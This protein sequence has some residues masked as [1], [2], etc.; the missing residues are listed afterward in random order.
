MSCAPSG[1]RRLIDSLSRRGARSSSPCGLSGSLGGLH[2]SRGAPARAS[3]RP[4][5]R[6]SRTTRV[7]LRSRLVV[8]L[9]SLATVLAIAACGS[10]SPPKTAESSGTQTPLAYV[11]C[12]RSHGVP[13]MPDPGAAGGIQLPA[14]VNPASPA[15]ES[16]LASCAR[17]M[18]A[19]A[20]EARSAPSQ[21]A[22]EQLL[23]LSR[24]MRSHGVAEFPDPTLGGPPSNPQDYSIAFGR[25]G[26]SMLVPSTV[27]VSSP[28]FKQAAVAC[29]FGALLPRGQRTPVPGS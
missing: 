6:W 23:A 26:V 10:S 29:H 19:G 3:L 4:C 13:Q 16:A 12:M 22:I 18:P 17:L 7:M 8:L 9:G 2:H 24:C 11:H 20:S 5:Y 25:G 27:D 28:A 14:D 21:Q 1:S 15:F